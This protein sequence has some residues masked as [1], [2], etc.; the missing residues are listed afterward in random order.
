MFWSPKTVNSLEMGVRTQLSIPKTSE[1]WSTNEWRLKTKIGD[2]LKSTK[3]SLIFEKPT[4]TNYPHEFE[5][6][7]EIFPFRR[8]SL[9]NSVEVWPNFICKRGK[10]N[11][12]YRLNFKNV[13]RPQSRLSVLLFP[14]PSRNVCDTLELISDSLLS[15][16]VQKLT[17]KKTKI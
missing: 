14:K 9:S 3:A 6:I 8:H 12:T 1:T 16:N 7:L 15:E 13:L 17:Y 4:K 2:Q 5:L 11:L 10:K